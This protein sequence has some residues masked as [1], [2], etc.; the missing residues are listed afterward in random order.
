M[1]KMMILMIVTVAAA[2]VG[3]NGAWPRRWCFRGDACSNCATY[4]TV[5]N[6]GYP[7]GTGLGANLSD[8]P[9]PADINE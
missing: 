4:E 1:K 8:F 6:T 3:C 7:M 2:S 9:G 5:T